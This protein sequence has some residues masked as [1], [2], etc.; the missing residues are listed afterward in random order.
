[1]NTPTRAGAI[2]ALIVRD[3]AE[4]PDRNSP[5]GWPEAML[6]TA[7]ELASIVTRHL[8]ALLSAGAE[9]VAMP[10]DDLLAAYM[11]WPADVRKKLSL[12]D[13]SRMRETM[14][15]PAPSAGVV[16]FDPMLIASMLRRYATALENDGGV[17]IGKYKPAAVREQA[18]LIEAS[19]GQ[20]VSAPASAAGE[21]EGFYLASFKHQSGSGHVMWWRPN[22]TGYTSDLNQAGVYLKIEDGYHDT[23]YT[24]PV[25]VAVI[26]E[27]RVRRE[28]DPGDTLNNG[29]RNAK[30]LREW[31]AR[32][33]GRE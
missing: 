3:V 17:R 7:D 5:E 1:M 4:L 13:L 8:P 15:R 28:V 27:L 21:S 11:Q 30:N 32:R 23:D 12:H 10:M 31:L 14:R 6:V 20:A 22:N 2:A 25:P 24:V 9:G 33:P 29:F 26:E 19:V 18:D 16:E